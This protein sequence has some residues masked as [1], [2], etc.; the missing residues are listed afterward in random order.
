M[1]GKTTSPSKGNLIPL[2]EAPRGPAGAPNNLGCVVLRRPINGVPCPIACLTVDICET[3]VA[4]HY[5]CTTVAT[6]TS[7]ATTLEAPS[8]PVRRRGAEI[9]SP[10]GGTGA[11][12]CGGAPPTEATRL[13]AKG[14]RNRPAKYLG[15]Y[16]GRYLGC[17]LAT[18][19]H[20][21]HGTGWTDLGR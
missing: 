4:H 6:T 17:F 1:S 19:Q 5:T 3:S 10:P 21:T 20:H 12:T 14:A 2:K 15:K 7:T 16:L 18:T 9:S 11:A 8:T 13:H